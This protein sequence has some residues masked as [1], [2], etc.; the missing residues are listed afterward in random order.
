MRLNRSAFA[1]FAGSAAVLVGGGT[2]ALARDGGNQSRAA[3]CEERLARIAERRGVTVAQLEAQ[4]KARLV[5]RVDAASQ[6]GR[7]T[8]DQ[9]ASLKERIAGAEICSRALHPLVR[10]GVR[11]MLRAAADFLGL[12]GA[13]LRAQL[14]GTSLVALAEKQGKSV[15]DLKAAML[16]PAKARL[17]QAVASGRITQARADLALDRLEKLV[18]R[19][20]VR[21]FPAK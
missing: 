20:V 21:T 1:A 9:A 11:G 14:P 16:A 2:A 12:S 10:H 8:P 5:A 17:A 13:E 4:I 6:A 3:R 7:I 18:D 19:L 15:D